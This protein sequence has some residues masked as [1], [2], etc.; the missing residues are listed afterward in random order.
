MN[1]DAADRIIKC[2][3]GRDHI[4]TPF[5][6][7]LLYLCPDAPPGTMYYLDSRYCKVTR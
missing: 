3:C 1:D 4:A 6:G 5:N 2:A 7:S